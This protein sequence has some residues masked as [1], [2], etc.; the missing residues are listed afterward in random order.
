M[1]I[2]ITGAAGFIGSHLLNTLSERVEDKV[3]GLDDLSQGD[4][5]R[6]HR[7]KTAYACKSESVTD[8][9]IVRRYENL[10]VIFHLAAVSRIQPSLQEPKR[11]FEVNVSGTINM[12]ELARHT[13]AHLVFISSSAAGGDLS[14]PYASSK[15]MGETLC[16]TY[17]KAYGV[18]TSV[19]RLFNVYGPYQRQVGA[20][21]TVIGRFIEQYRTKRPLTVTG[22]GS[23]RRDFVH[24]AD[25]VN[26]LIKIAEHSDGASNVYDL[27]FGKNYSIL[28]VAKMFQ[29]DKIEFLPE[30]R[31]EDQSTL[32]DIRVAKEK[33]GYSPNFSLP[34]YIRAFTNGLR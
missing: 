28:E 8:A 12:L 3:F 26:G 15:A 9:S 14:N 20:Y 25:V 17:H 31:G 30:R 16:S 7:A 19:A 33:I 27:G 13:G 2:L 18:K 6:I 24:V 4:L 29:S 10:Q 32:A 34:E 22:D 23:K 21:S 1:N 11:T 5:K